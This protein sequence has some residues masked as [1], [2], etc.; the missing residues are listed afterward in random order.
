MQT[1]SRA[2]KITPKFAGR[3]KG[4]MITMG[5]IPE[6]IKNIDKHI[7]YLKKQET[8]GKSKE[9][10]KKNKLTVLQQQSNL[11]MIIIHKTP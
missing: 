1:L 3:C 4:K 2:H 5:S 7:S 11:V 10:E 9:S 8:P 6:V